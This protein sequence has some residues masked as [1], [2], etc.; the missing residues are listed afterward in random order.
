MKSIGEY[1]DTYRV[2]GD[3]LSAFFYDRYIVERV[4]DPGKLYVLQKWN[5]VRFASS[6]GYIL[7]LKTTCATLA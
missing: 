2:I 4:S 1:I 5:T 6:Q 7:F 3:Q